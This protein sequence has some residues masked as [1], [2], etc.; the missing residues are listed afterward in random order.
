VPVGAYEIT[1]EEV[2]GM[3]VSRLK[4]SKVTKSTAASGAV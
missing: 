2:D 3:R 1:V 4:L